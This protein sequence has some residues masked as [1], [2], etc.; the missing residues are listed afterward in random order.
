[1][2]IIE[3]IFNFIIGSL[4]ALWP[5]P[6]PLQARLSKCRIVAHRGVHESQLAQENSMAAFDLA[7][8][9]QIWA[10]ETDVR[11]TANNVPVIS[12]DPD[13]GR[14]FQRPDIVID[15]TTAHQL[16]HEI[17]EVP[18]LEEVCAS[19]GHRLHLMIEIKEDLRASPKKVEALKNELSKLNPVTDYHL[20]CLSPEYL[21][22]LT[23]APKAAFMDVIWLDPKAVLTKNRDLQHGAV[24]GHFLFLPTNIVRRLQADGKK[25]GV[26]FLDSR[27]SLY[28]EINRGADFVFT[29]HPLRLKSYLADRP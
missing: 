22:A 16:K 2:T 4:F 5:R 11:F 24:A 8:K 12:H 26:G 17:P 25:V 7:L 15:Q 1:M 10:I 28:R 19:F 14:L 3:K 21:E 20:L 27:N 29:N 9:N 6:R 18:T 23:F 13:C